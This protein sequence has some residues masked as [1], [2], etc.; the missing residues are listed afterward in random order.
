M[1]SIS[2]FCPYC[3]KEVTFSWV[4]LSES[5][6]DIRNRFREYFNN[7]LAAWMV[8]ECPS[9][10]KCVLIEYSLK[11]NGY[12]D[13]LR[14]IFPSPLPSPVDARMPDK[15]KKDLQEAKLCFSVGAIN[16]SA[17]MARRAI[18]RACKEMGATKR[19][20]LDQIDEIASSGII[21]QPLKELAHTVRLVGNDGA[22]PNEE[23]VEEQD[24]KEILELAEQFMGVVFVAPARVKEIKEKRS[25]P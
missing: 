16:A 20:L 8:G 22:H 1:N 23:D 2:A 18:Q 15:I 12:P 24:V 21:T 10:K 6:G 7:N 19:E 11:E 9:C 17:T 3:H 5:G 13:S 4:F 25:Q 14:K